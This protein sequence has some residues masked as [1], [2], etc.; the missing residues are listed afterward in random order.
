MKYKVDGKL[1][2]VRPLC[3]HMHWP[4]LDQGAGS[5]AAAAPIRPPR[6]WEDIQLLPPPAQKKKKKKPRGGDH[7]EGAVAGNQRGAA[8]S[9]GLSEMERDRGRGRR[10][11]LKAVLPHELQSS[12]DDEER[13]GNRGRGGGGIVGSHGEDRPG[14]PPHSGGTPGEAKRRRR[15]REEGWEKDDDTPL[16]LLRSKQRRV[17]L[18]D[19]GRPA[20]TVAAAAAA[21]ATST[22]AVAAASDAD[23]DG[24]LYNA[25][26]PNASSPSRAKILPGPDGSGSRTLDPDPYPPPRASSPSQVQVL[27]NQEPQSQR[28]SPM[29]AAPLLNGGPAGPNAAEAVT[30]RG[31]PATSQGVGV[32]VPSPRPGPQ[33]ALTV[34]LP[35]PVA[36]AIPSPDGT[37]SGAASGPQP[38]VPQSVVPPAA[39]PLPAAVAAVLPV[40][41][42]PLSAVSPLPP[43]P[44]PAAAVPVLAIPL[45][46]VLRPGDVP[47]SRPDPRRRLTVAAEPAAPSSDS[48]AAAAAAAPISLSA[49]S[50]GE[51]KPSS[52]AATAPA[53]TAADA[54]AAA[55]K[56]PSG[57]LS[58]SHWASTSSSGGDGFSF[59]S[60]P[61]QPFE[62]VWEARGRVS[63][64]HPGQTTAQERAP[65]PPGAGS[66][67]GPAATLPSHPTREPDIDSDEERDDGGSGGGGEDDTLAG[68]DGDDALPLSLS[69]GLPDL[70]E[71]PPASRPQRVVPEQEAVP[72][73]VVVPEQRV[74]PEH[75]AAAAMDA[76]PA[77][78]EPVPP[79]RATSAPAAAEQA[80]RVD[81]APTPAIPPRPV[82]HPPKVVTGP[83]PPRPVLHPPTMVTEPVP[84][85]AGASGGA[86][87][88]A[89]TQA[90]AQPS[91][92]RGAS[93]RG[94]TSESAEAVALSR[95]ASISRSWRKAQA[96][97]V[98]VRLDPV[99]DEASGLLAASLA[100]DP[101][102]LL[103]A[104]RV[105]GHL[106][107]LSPLPRPSV[108]ALAG[109]TAAATVSPGSL[110]LEVAKVVGE[111]GEPR[112]WLPLF[113]DGAS[114][115]AS[116][117]AGSRHSIQQPRTPLRLIELNGQGGGAAIGSG[118][119]NGGGRAS[120]RA[121]L[122]LGVP[123]PN[124]RI[125]A[126]IRALGTA[127][128]A[129][130]AAAAVGVVDGVRLDD[131]AA[132][133]TDGGGV[134]PPSSGAVRQ[135]PAVQSSPFVRLVGEGSL[136]TEQLQLVAELRQ[137]QQQ[138]Q[139]H[140]PASASVGRGSV[141]GPSSGGSSSVKCPWGIVCSVLRA[142]APPPAPMP[143]R[144]E[145]AAVGSDHLLQQA[146]QQATQQSQQA[147]EQAQQATQQLQ[148]P[149][150]QRQGPG[151][152]QDLFPNLLR[153]LLS[154]EPSPRLAAPPPSIWRCHSWV[155]GAWR[156]MLYINPTMGHQGRKPSSK[157]CYARLVGGGE[158]E[159]GAARRGGFGVMGGGWGAQVRFFN[160]SASAFPH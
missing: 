46:A 124:S 127:A 156:L 130:A 11:I 85:A 142:A 107:A 69:S 123:G 63:A 57:S 103:L 145:S 160:A 98:V 99:R 88:A 152:V 158:W 73:Q 140:A 89:A 33:P 93:S 55:T 48:E 131:A 34:L 17:G 18:P 74:L 128:A 20:T 150:Q 72:E 109:G 78:T 40:L 97:A 15:E 84:A 21:A 31:E 51:P 149:P 49:R 26:L 24:L 120:R 47:L 136:R 4:P 144:A 58:L 134:R 82:L 90:R 112:A 111:D 71:L 87:E 125:E 114:A 8:E 67:T 66:V 83:V 1:G 42:V 12:S 19:M 138:Q 115:A 23:D 38:A 117:S 52:A 6:R 68:Q 94:A 76:P 30:R 122:L 36:L 9:P 159:W 141:L 104:K 50:S 22:A 79:Y 37:L 119:G 129:A 143:R 100:D 101:T 95:A 10:A 54:T 25:P 146:P 139:Q 147:P 132:A 148:Q 121:D 92:S 7:H 135:A 157:R 60:H 108:E 105:H 151:E 3:N 56:R 32:S 45:S 81:T 96:H 14:R 44:L 102:F 126:V 53:T 65:G 155:A 106:S 28:I 75:T 153:G 61:Q 5:A 118:G 16:A 29:A 43:V 133:A 2:N 35:R 91:T 39:V 113:R 62:G 137:Q 154:Q 13:G 59:Q 27:S 41:A 86:A 110:L 116:A 70:P 64:A 80:A 77:H